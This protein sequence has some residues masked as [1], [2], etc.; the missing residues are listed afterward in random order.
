[1]RTRKDE[2][3]EEARAFH[4]KHPEVWREFVRLTRDRIDMGF[5]HYSAYAI[6]ERIRWSLDVVG[7]DGG[8]SFKINNNYRPIYARWF[9]RKFPQHEGFFRTRAMPSED[10]PATGMDPLGPADFPYT[11]GVKA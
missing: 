10:Q 9:M 5:T 8:S 7:N 6:F 3:E 2:L 4:A 1:M 11:N